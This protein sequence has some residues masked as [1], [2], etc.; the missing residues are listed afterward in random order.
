MTK[1]KSKRPKSTLRKKETKEIPADSKP[2]SKKALTQISSSQ[3]PTQAEKEVR[4][5]KQI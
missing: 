5:C 3:R 4:H 2:H 1:A